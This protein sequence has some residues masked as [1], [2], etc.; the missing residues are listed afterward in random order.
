MDNSTCEE[1]LCQLLQTYNKQFN[2][3][4]TFPTG[5]KTIFNVKTKNNEFNFTTSITDEDVFLQISILPG[6]YE[7]RK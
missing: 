7:L 3:A 2:V 4:I 5:Y 6:A 1:K